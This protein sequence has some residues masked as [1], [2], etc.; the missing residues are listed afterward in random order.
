MNCRAANT[1]VSSRPCRGR[2]RWKPLLGGRFA[3][4]FADVADDLSGL[5][6]G[7]ALLQHGVRAIP[8]HFSIGALGNPCSQIV[9]RHFPD[10][11]RY[12][13]GGF[14]SR[15][16]LTPLAVTL[17]APLPIQSTTRVS[18][19]RR[20]RGIQD[21]QQESAASGY[22]SKKLHWAAPSRQATVGRD[23]ITAN[24]CAIA[25]SSDATILA[26]LKHGND[27]D[28]SGR[29]GLQRA[30]SW[31]KMCPPRCSL[32]P[33]IRSRYQTF[34]SHHRVNE[35]EEPVG[36]HR[37]EQPKNRE[38]YKNRPKHSHLAL[39]ATSLFSTRS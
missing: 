2:E 16:S 22:N 39:P 6:G 9:V 36:T 4:H 10:L 1:R 27:G 34:G 31:S 13:T 28:G 11:L 32:C 35:S 17:G 37:G 30:R 23:Q 3:L 26:Q 20:S 38:D 15:A 12:Q 24:Y 14:D 7:E 33:V 29:K 8:F 18:C 5:I 19:K 25:R 21:S